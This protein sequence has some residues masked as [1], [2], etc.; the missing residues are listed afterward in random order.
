VGPGPAPRRTRLR[1]TRRHPKAL[2]WHSSYALIKPLAAVPAERPDFQEIVTAI[3]AD[4]DDVRDDMIAVYQVMCKLGL[5]HTLRGRGDSAV[6]VHPKV[7]RRR[8]D[9]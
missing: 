1:K 7:T 3:K 4:L 8:E 2:E 5:P 6:C 9:P